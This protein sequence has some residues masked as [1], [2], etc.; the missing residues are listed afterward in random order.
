M[1][2]DCDREPSLNPM[3]STLRPNDQVCFKAGAVGG[4]EQQ[5]E[6]MPRICLRF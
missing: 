4:Q 6:M 5:L 1:R 2:G 3:V